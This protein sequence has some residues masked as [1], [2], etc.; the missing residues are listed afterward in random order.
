MGAPATTYFCKNGHIVLDLAHHQIVLDEPK[1]CPYCKSTEI[2]S[3]TE[4]YDWDEYHWRED[5]KPVPMDPPYEPLRQEAH[6]VFVPVYD[7]S[8]L[9]RK[10]KK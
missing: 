7:V 3:V 9:F 4:W 1:E 8:R 5:G 10:E 6:T 2:K